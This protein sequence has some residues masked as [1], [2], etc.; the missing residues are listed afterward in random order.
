MV[1]EVSLE[2]SKVFA[3]LRQVAL[4]VEVNCYVQNA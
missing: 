2:S 3:V 4:V 1:V